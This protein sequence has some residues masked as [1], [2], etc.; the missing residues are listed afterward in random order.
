MV[1]YIGFYGGMYW[2]HNTLGSLLSLVE[3]KLEHLFH[4]HIFIR[5]SLATIASTRDASSTVYTVLSA[6]TVSDSIH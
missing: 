4:I 2:V 5:T 1:L 6:N 3:C